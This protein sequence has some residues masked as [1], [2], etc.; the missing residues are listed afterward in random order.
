MVTTVNL[1]KHKNGHNTVSFT[2]IELQFIS[3]ESFLT[4]YILFAL[5]ALTRSLFKRLPCKV[6]IRLPSR[7]ANFIDKAFA[8]RCPL[9]NTKICISWLYY[10]FE[11][12]LFLL[13]SHLF[14]HCCVGLI[15]VQVP[16]LLQLWHTPSSSLAI[17]TEA[18]SRITWPN[19]SRAG[20]CT[21]VT[22]SRPW[23]HEVSHMCSAVIFPSITAQLWG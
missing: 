23:P 20:V 4:Y 19:R 1:S 11:E 15:K 17:H 22:K 21:A 13:Y 9:K 3:C 7:K 10:L 2:N 6:R 14:L 5:T 18:R 8:I 16:L 12:S